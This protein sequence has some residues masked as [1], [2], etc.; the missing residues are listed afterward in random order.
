[1]VMLA[2]LPNVVDTVASSLLYF[3]SFVSTKAGTYNGLQ[4]TVHKG[5][6][7]VYA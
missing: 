6:W 1:M 3:I 4:K 2:V 7:I 5:K